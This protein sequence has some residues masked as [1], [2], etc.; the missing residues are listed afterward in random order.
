MNQVEDAKM[1]KKLTI[2]WVKKVKRHQVRGELTIWE[3]MTAWNK[4]TIRETT[5]IQKN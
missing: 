4:L 3:E 5:T 1:K 2:N